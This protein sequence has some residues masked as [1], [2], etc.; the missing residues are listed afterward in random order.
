MTADMSSAAANDSAAPKSK[1]AYWRSLSE[2]RDSEDFQV[3]LDRE[4][5]VAA[6]EFPEGVSRRRWMQLMG[7]SMAMVGV[8]G[9]RYP[10]EEILPFV[11]RPEGRVPGETYLRSTNF[12]LAGR[13][14]NLLVE[15]FDGRPLKVEA[16]GDHP[17]GSCTDTYSQAAI[18]ELYDPD[19]ARGKDAAIWR[20]GTERREAVSWEDFDA[21]GQQLLD[22]AGDG[23]GFAFVMAPT[24]SPSLIRMLSKL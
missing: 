1:P 4:F 19:R 20:R 10:E 11:I 12:E 21:F 15:N 23:S 16:N 18:L 24:H 13:V 8:A 2:L 14:Y 22:N 7:A 9:C 5:P 17:S 3:H 6:S